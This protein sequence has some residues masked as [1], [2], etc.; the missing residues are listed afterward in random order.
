[1][2]CFLGLAYPKTANK[3]NSFFSHSGYRQVEIK[4]SLGY[5]CLGTERKE[6]WPASPGCCC[7]CSSSIV[8][9]RRL[10]PL[11]LHLEDT[12]SLS[13]SMLLWA[14]QSSP[15]RVPTRPLCLMSFTSSPEE[16]SAIA[17]QNFCF[18]LL[19][20]QR[21]LEWKETMWTFKVTNY[22]TLK[23]YKIDY[24]SEYLCTIFGNEQVK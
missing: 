6:L 22:F 5:F 1:M 24:D 23:M 2:F 15:G 9:D 13:F 19:L 18:G 21:N 16:V 3:R 8:L 12:R 7:L 20:L 10:H 17:V 4:A 14:S 11:G